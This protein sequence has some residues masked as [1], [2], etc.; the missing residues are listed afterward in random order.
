MP[1]E[2]Y[3]MIYSHQSDELPNSST[4]LVV[5]I[6]KHKKN[7][8]TASNLRTSTRGTHWKMTDFLDFRLQFLHR[9]RLH[10]SIGWTIRGPSSRF[11]SV[12]IGSNPYSPTGLVVAVT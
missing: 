3:L 10:P 8:I 4:P 12:H 2:I 6:Y 1:R 7:R 11:P 9:Q 5:L